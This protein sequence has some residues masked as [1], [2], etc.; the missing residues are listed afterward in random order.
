[1]HAWRILFHI[2][3]GNEIVNNLLDTIISCLHLQPTRHV[4]KYFVLQNQASNFDQKNVN[5][6]DSA[7]YTNKET[8]KI[9]KETINNNQKRNKECITASN[10]HS[11]QRQTDDIIEMTRSN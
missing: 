1:M 7:I 11:N 6:K 4:D 3:E 2:L 9:N 8:I 5:K 10:Q